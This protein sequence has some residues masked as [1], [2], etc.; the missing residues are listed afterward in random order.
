MEYKAYSFDLDDNLL[1]LPTSVYL[2][3]EKGEMQEFSTSEFEKIR[4]NLGKLNLEVT[5][6]SYKSFLDDNQFMIDINNSTKAGSWRNLEKCIVKHSSIFSIITARGLS[7]LALRRGLKQIIIKNISKD[8]LEIFKDNFLEKYNIE[9][10]DNS[11]EKVLDIYLD[12]C[13]FYPVNNPE[14]KKRFGTEEMG[15]LK[16]LAFEEFQ[17]YVNLYV[18]EKFGEDTIVKIGFSDDSDS[19]LSKMI[20]HVLQKQGLFFYK[21]DEEG[22]N[23][24]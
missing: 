20:S 14:I 18:K 7:P 22:A 15:E 5:K 1:K 2:K 4:P 9:T 11:I 10:E 16:S 23:L 12:L 6:D 24:F 19:H 8:N 3:N 21:T 17:G 13:R